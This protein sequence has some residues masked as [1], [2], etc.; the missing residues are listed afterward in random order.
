M[1]NSSLN[2][3]NY[4]NLSDFLQERPIISVGS[5]NV[6]IS[7]LHLT[8][9]LLHTFSYFGHLHLGSRES[10][11]KYGD[12]QD[13]FWGVPEGDV[14]LIFGLKTERQRTFRVGAEVYGAG[15]TGRETKN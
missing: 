3:E 11:R 4:F 9:G 6:K 15:V 14:S 12:G 5:L 1:V 10:R 13:D 2:L 8:E 7:F